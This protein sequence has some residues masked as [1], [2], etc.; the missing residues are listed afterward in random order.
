MFDA[1][2]CRLTS[3][4]QLCAMLMI[5]FSKLGAVMSNLA[6]RSYS[7]IKLLYG[8]VGWKSFQQHSKEPHAVLLL[9]S[10]V[11][12]FSTVELRKKSS[13]FKRILC[14]LPLNL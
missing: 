10:L 11:L 1:Q 3:S 9:S 8:Y 7:R 2:V 6:L 4:L 5:Y 14:W 13:S 12:R